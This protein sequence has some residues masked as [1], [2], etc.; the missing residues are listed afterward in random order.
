MVVLQHHDFH[1]LQTRQAKH[2]VALGLALVAGFVH[3]PYLSLD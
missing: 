3:H 2:A 1:A